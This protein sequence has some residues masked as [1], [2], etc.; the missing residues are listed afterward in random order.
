MR[1][2]RFVISAVAAALL[3]CGLPSCSSTDSFISDVSMSKCYNM[4]RAGMAME[5]GGG[6]GDS[7]DVMTYDEVLTLTR[8]G[9]DIC[10]EWSGV[11]INCM[12]SNVKVDCEKGDGRIDIRYTQVFDSDIAAACSCPVTLYF[13]IRDA[14]QD[15]FLLTIQDIWGNARSYDIDFQ[16]RDT[17]TIDFRKDKPI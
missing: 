13:T 3:A 16:G 10:C 7:L 17:A 12:A 11:L 6:E 8:S 1:T 2:K 15:R 14:A 4:T 5:D 9:Q